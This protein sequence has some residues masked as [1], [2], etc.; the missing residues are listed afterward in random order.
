[1]KRPAAC[2]KISSR[3]PAAIGT[4]AWSCFLAPNRRAS[5]DLPRRLCA[6]SPRRG[7]QRHCR[8]LSG[9]KGFE[10]NGAARLVGK[11]S[12]HLVTLSLIRDLKRRIIFSVRCPARGAFLRRLERENISA[13]LIEALAPKTR[14]PE[15]IWLSARPISFPLCLHGEFLEPGMHVSCVK[16]CELD[17]TTYRRSEPLIIHWREPSPFKSRLASTASRSPT[18][19]TVGSTRLP[20][21]IGD[22]GF[23]TLSELVNRPTSRKDRK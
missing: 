19:Q 16:P 10:S 12:A 11:P 3:W 21:K 23:P 6:E 22:L 2:A 13:E 18:Y 5:G 17:A 20:G 8:P 4:L 15:S 14:S 1:M 7:R 9:P